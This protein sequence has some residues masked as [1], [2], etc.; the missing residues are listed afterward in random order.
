MQQC[1]SLAD[2]YIAEKGEATAMR[3]YRG[4]ASKFFSG[5]K[6]A[7]YYKNRLSTELVD[8][9]SLVRILDAIKEEIT[10]Q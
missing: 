3:I 10:N 2:Y 4:I 6:N 1:L 9:E 8:R 5:F 7:K